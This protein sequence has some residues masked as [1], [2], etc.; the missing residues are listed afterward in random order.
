MEGQVR[1][2]IGCGYTCLEKDGNDRI[3]EK[4]GITSLGMA[5][6]K[7]NGK[8]EEDQIGRFYKI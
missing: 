3:L 7:W 6:Q 5:F 8:Y 4:I 1:D 2:W